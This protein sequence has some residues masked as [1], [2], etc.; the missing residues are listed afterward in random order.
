M[1]IALEINKPCVRGYQ[2]KAGA[3]NSFTIAGRM[4]CVISLAGRKKL[5]LLNSLSFYFKPHHCFCQ[6]FPVLRSQKS[7]VVLT[8]QFMEKILIGAER[9]SKNK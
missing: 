3:G 5:I 9:P 4:N 8:H 7:M 1:S 2:S 6:V